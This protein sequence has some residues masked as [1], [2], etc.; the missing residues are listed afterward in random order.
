MPAN[1]P[2]L[3]NSRR[4]IDRFEFFIIAPEPF[5]AGVSGLPERTSAIVH[6]AIQMVIVTYPDGKLFMATHRSTK[7]RIPRHSL[8]CQC[9]IMKAP[10]TGSSGGANIRDWKA[11]MT[12]N[13]KL[14]IAL[15]VAVTAG[16][17]AVAA[18][19]GRAEISKRDAQA[20]SK[21][22]LIYIATVRKDGNQSKAAPVWFTTSADNNAILI[23]TGPETWKTKRIRRGSPALVWIGTA[24]GPAFIGKA[25][26]TN[27]NRTDRAEKSNR[28]AQV[29]SECPPSRPARRPGGV[30]PAHALVRD[31]ATV[32][33]DV[34]W[35]LSATTSL[36]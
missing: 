15:T 17:I 10:L 1:A 22:D 35:R 14:R 13:S 26:I 9:D 16:L 12:I 28:F 31:K 11:P 2:L 25:E 5:R 24:D 23:Q 32:V 34:D 19:N 29:A 33:F 6:V 7:N 8:V 4:P 21:A 3:M 20:L 18:S 36:S 30:A 27:G